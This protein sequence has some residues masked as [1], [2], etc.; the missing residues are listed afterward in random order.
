[1]ATASIIQDAFPASHLPVF[2]SRPSPRRAPPL[3]PLPPDRNFP[4][5]PA[6]ARGYSAFP[7][8]HDLNPGTEPL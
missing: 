1:M 6:G 2:P 7:S 5:P 8:T 3:P 4:L